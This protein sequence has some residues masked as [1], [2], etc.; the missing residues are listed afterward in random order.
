MANEANNDLSGA[1]SNLINTA[2]QLIKQEI[3]LLGAGFNA[4]V[5]VIEPLGKTAID[6]VGSASNTVGGLLQNAAS[7]IAPKK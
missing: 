7:A 5:Q 4:V 6:L 3:D 1:V 2:G